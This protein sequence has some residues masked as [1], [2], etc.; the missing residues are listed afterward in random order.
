MSSSTINCYGI[1]LGATE[2]TVARLRGSAVHVFRNAEGAE[3]T[4][5]AVYLNKANS[6]VVGRSAKEKCE[7]DPGNAFREFRRDMGSGTEYCFARNGRRMK[8]EELSAEVLKSLC[9]DVQR[10]TGETVNAAV[11]TVPADF[12]TPQT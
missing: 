2:A 6:L 5:C 9:A 10:A 11:I 7:S 4:P 3:S 1:D 12:D 8:P